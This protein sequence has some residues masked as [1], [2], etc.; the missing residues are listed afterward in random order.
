M[1]VKKKKPF[2]QE[3][4][5]NR[6]VVGPPKDQ[7]GKTAADYPKQKFRLS[8]GGGERE[9][10]EEEYKKVRAKLRTEDIIARAMA[11]PGG[12]KPALTPEERI[13][14][15]EAFRKLVEK[16]KGEA[17]QYEPGPKTTQEQRTAESGGLI[18]GQGILPQSKGGLPF[19]N[20]RNLM[21]GEAFRLTANIPIPTLE[22]AT[23]NSIFF[24][25]YKKRV[26]EIVSDATKLDD[27]S[28]LIVMS[29]KDGGDVRGAINQ[30]MRLEN[31]AT[32][33]FDEANQEMRN[34]PD[35]RRLGIDVAEE[36]FNGISTLQIRRFML[37]KYL[38]TGD[39]TELEN[40]ILAS[41]IIQEQN[42]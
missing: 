33:K 1:P 30:L 9:V 3:A 8:I 16:Q 29:A 40:F 19:E 41:K 5:V 28:R 20:T 24:G 10:S 25:D 13:A 11:E 32:E 37:E 23:I 42:I 17:I 34:N 18:I 31:S 2:E 36:R 26:A 27:T 22:G 21:V 38:V 6:D 14:K 12:R 4:V 7:F 35:A 39:S 15:E